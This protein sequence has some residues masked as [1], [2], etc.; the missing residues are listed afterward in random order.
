VTRANGILLA[1]VVGRMVCDRRWMAMAIIVPVLGV[2]GVQ[3]WLIA[4]GYGMSPPARS[5][6]VRP[7][8]SP[9]ARGSDRARIS[10]DRGPGPRQSDRGPGHRQKFGSRK[11]RPRFFNGVAG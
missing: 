1:L 4:A 3:T 8:P 11:S 10:P 9:T 2:L 7:T 6:E 5:R